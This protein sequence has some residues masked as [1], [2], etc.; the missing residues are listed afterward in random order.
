MAR[1]TIKNVR[2]AGVSAAVPKNIV[3]T[4]D[5][6]FFTK[7]EAETF[8]NT[9]GIKERRLGPETL[10]ASDMCY[11]AAE[12]LLADL[13]WERESIDVLIFESVTGDYKTPPTSCL[14]QEC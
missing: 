8:N 14:L 7:E 1:W 2:V 13:G 3:K 4:S 11:A 10:C 6:D 12:K 5:F 9:V